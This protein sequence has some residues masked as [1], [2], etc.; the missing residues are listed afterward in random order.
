MNFIALLT[1]LFLIRLFYERDF[2][3][4]KR[5]FQ[6]KRHHLNATFQRQL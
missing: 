3:Q 5:S 6:K 1:N 4:K 2:S